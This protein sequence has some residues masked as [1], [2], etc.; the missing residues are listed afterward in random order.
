[1]NLATART[2]GPA[3]KTHARFRCGLSVRGQPTSSSPRC[4]ISKVSNITCKTTDH[5]STTITQVSITSNTTHRKWGEGSIGGWEYSC[6]NTPLLSRYETYCIITV[7]IWIKVRSKNNKHPQRQ[8]SGHNTSLD[9]TGQFTS[10]G[11]YCGPHTAFFVFLILIHT[12]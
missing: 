6:C 11:E 9:H 2:T 5:L 4:D 12:N 10:L 7:W 1:M 8:Y 3:W